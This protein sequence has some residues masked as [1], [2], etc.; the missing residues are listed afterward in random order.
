MSETAL[1]RIQPRIADIYM[2]TEEGLSIGQIAKRIGVSSRTLEKAMEQDPDL[3]DVLQEAEDRFLDSVESSLA[4]NALPMEVEEVEVT[5]LPE[6]DQIVKRK[7]KM[8][9]GSLAAQKEILHNRRPE[10]W[11][12]RK[13]IEIKKSVDISVTL[14]SP[15]EHIK[16]PHQ[17]EIVV[18]AIKDEAM[19]GVLEDE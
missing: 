16:F 6:G 18:D 8:Q 19:E 5:T 4:R 7:T 1:Q 15:P 14:P 11:A 3:R 17:E 2:L 10:K 9:E 12:S 13:A